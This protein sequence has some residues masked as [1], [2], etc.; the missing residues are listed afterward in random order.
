VATEQTFTVS[1]LHTEWLM[2]RNQ[3][4]DNFP[5]GCDLI[6]CADNVIVG[7]PRTATLRFDEEGA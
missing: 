2:A 5:T 6:L 3:W 1:G 7:V 4:C